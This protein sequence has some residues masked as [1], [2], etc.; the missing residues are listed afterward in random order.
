MPGLQVQIEHRVRQHENV[1]SE[2]GVR[3]V[4]A[5]EEGAIRLV[6]AATAGVVVQLL[7]GREPEIRNNGELRAE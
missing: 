2:V 4:A 6:V 1:E 7:V 3:R 5:G